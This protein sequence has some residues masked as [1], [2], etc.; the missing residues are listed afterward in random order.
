MILAI[1]MVPVIKLDNVKGVNILKIGKT[2]H[3][4]KQIGVQEQIMDLKEVL[5]GSKMLLEEQES[6]ENVVQ[7]KPRRRL[8][9]WKEMYNT[10]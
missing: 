10:K 5:I 4:M 8:G 2:I 6:V 1:G 7:L 9:E 3:G